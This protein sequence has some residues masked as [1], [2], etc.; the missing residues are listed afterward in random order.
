MAPE[1]DDKL[2]FKT[3][4]FC[5]LGQFYKRLSCNGVSYY[6]KYIH[7]NMFLVLLNTDTHT[8]YFG[9]ISFEESLCTINIPDLHTTKN[10]FL[11]M[12]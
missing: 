2:Y 8:K 4:V 10:L 7:Q 5:M 3:L 6:R 11:I 12:Y 1:T 9:D